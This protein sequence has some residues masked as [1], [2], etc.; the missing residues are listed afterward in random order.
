MDPTGPTWSHLVPHGPT[1]S[2]LVL[3]SSNWSHL[4][5]TGPTWFHLVPPGPS[6]ISSGNRKEIPSEIKGKLQSNPRVHCKTF[7]QT[8]NKNLPKWKISD[9][10]IL[11]YVCSRLLI[12]FDSDNILHSVLPRAGT[13]I[14]LLTLHV[15]DFISL[16][17]KAKYP[18][19]VSLEKLLKN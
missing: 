11:C 17:K 9:C 13:Q 16:Y 14:F 19:F 3:R 1:W 15:G 8:L 6:I 18:K 7:P 4:V 10:S 12:T 2:H 5:P